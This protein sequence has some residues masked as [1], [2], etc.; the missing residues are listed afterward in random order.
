MDEH[1]GGDSNSSS[2]DHAR[3]DVHA[4]TTT[5]NIQCLLETVGHDL[6]ALGFPIFFVLMD[7]AK[8]QKPKRRSVCVFFFFAINSLKR[9]AVAVTFEMCLQSCYRVCSCAIVRY[10]HVPVR[11]AMVRTNSSLHLKTDSLSHSSSPKV[12][13]VQTCAV[14]LTPS[15]RKIAVTPKKSVGTR[16][17]Q[18]QDL[19][20]SGQNILEE[21]RSPRP[22]A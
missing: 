6:H 17:H 14:L 9:S 10:S 3:S 18:I 20:V 21:K 22:I 8:P 1:T 2:T 12:M 15:V 7:Q 11:G 13:P 16:F 19:A 5:C 4:N